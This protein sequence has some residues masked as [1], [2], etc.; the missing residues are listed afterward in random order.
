LSRNCGTTI[1]AGDGRCTP[2]GRDDRWHRYDFARPDS[3][4]APL[5]A[6]IDDDITGLFWG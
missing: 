5:L 2:A 4:I 1:A 6:A 3:D